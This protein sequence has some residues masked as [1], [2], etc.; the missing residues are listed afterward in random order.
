M[1]ALNKKVAGLAFLF[2][3][4]GFPDFTK[5]FWVRQALK[6]YRRARPRKD[7]RRLVSFEVLQGILTRLPEVCA[8]VYE[9]ALF[10]VAFALAF[11]G[12]FRISELVSPSKKVHGGCWVAR[13]VVRIVYPCGCTGQIRIKGGRV[14]WCRFFEFLKVRPD[15]VG[16]FL[17]H[18]DGLP[19]SKF[20]FISVFRKG[21]RSLGLESK[22]FSSH[23][24]RIGAA[25]EVV[26]CGLN[27][28]WA[29]GI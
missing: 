26:W 19:L 23:S 10:K 22:Q 6:G 13:C 24:F 15:G 8:S 3:W 2:K 21:L 16:S 9:A 28:D 20:Q 29:M 14:R 5:D 27:A 7:T 4:Q 25:T 17:M 1:A 12:A 11:F 18:A